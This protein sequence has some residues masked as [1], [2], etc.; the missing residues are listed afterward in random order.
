MHLL[1]I[2]TVDGK[3]VNALLEEV[4][5]NMLAL[6]DKLDNTPLDCP[7]SVYNQV[8]VPLAFLVGIFSLLYVVVF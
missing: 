8:W 1:P 4:H 5:A 3:D 7:M 6:Q 2:A